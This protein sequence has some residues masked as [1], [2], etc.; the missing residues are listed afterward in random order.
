MDKPTKYKNCSLCAKRG[1][2]W[3]TKRYG[4]RGE[5]GKRPF[6]HEAVCSLF[7]IDKPKDW[8]AQ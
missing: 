5:R 4:E 7:V 3:D 1:D 6:P 8:E 2:C